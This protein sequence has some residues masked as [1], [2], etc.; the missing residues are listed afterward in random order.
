MHKFQ[1]IY[2]IPSHRMPQWDYSGNGMYIITLVM[3]HRECSLVEI[4]DGEMFLSDFGMIV[5]N[6]WIKSFELRK[7]LFCDEYVIM[8][9]PFHH[10]LQV[11][12]RR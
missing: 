6:E 2:R 8:P 4:I 3:Q 12:N 5:K 11:S 10:L 9:N 7:E 1:N